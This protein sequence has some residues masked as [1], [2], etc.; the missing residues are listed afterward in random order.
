MKNE[1]KCLFDFAA[2]CLINKL[3]INAFFKQRGERG[4]FQIISYRCDNNV[5]L[6]SCKWW[7]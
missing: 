6:Q 4:T 7:H 5:N 2:G 1:L 3:K